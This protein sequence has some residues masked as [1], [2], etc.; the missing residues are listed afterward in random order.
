MAKEQAERGEAEAHDFQVL[1]EDERLDALAK[2][3]KAFEEL[4][5]H[6]DRI[7]ANARRVKLL[8]L[9]EKLIHMRG[10]EPSVADPE[11]HEVD[12]QGEV[13][14]KQLADPGDVLIDIHTPISFGPPAQAEEGV[15]ERGEAVS[16]EDNIDA[17]N[18]NGTQSF[19]EL[20]HHVRVEELSV[21]ELPP[22]RLD[23]AADFIGP[24]PKKHFDPSQDVELERVR[25]KLTKN[26]LL[27]E[28]VLPAGTIIAVIPVDARHI[29][30][31]G[32]AEYATPSE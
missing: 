12:A 22:L 2:V 11:T 5:A 25:L 26:G 28:T 19:P 23:H 32:M 3:R 10:T 21:E 13:E 17:P 4:D 29:L 15:H 6:P 9:W 8:R 30:E 24:M 18:Q 20:L 7:E 1:N 27:H 31:S 16:F 14:V